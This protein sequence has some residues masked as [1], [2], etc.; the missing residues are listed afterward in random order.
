M[1]TSVEAKQA[2]WKEGCEGGYVQPRET[3]DDRV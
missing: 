3:R 1:E 2:R